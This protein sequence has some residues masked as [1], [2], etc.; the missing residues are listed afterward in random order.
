MTYNENKRA[1]RNKE[2]GETARPKTWEWG[3]CQGKNK[4]RERGNLIMGDR[5]Q[6]K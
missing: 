3:I 6:N 1:K 2:R 4:A 5:A